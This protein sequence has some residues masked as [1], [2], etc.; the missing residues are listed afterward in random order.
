M[1]AE[2]KQI[3]KLLLFNYCPLITGV[4]AERRLEEVVG[5]LQP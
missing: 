3:L 2:R 5:L 1:R 4:V